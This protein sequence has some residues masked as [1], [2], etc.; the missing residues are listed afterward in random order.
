MPMQ[1]PQ[2]RQLPRA[3]KVRDAADALGVSVRT[4]NALLANRSLPSVLVGR[5]CRRIL[6]ADVIDYIDRNKKC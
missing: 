2:P 5:R 1:K 4:L 3:L 6:E